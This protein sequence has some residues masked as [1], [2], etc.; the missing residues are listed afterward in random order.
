LIHAWNDRSCPKKEHASLLCVCVSDIVVVGGG[1]A[2]VPCWM[3][4]SMFSMSKCRYR[5][6]GIV[7]SVPFSW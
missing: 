5:T 7:S 2:A 6:I 3:S 1:T 4:M